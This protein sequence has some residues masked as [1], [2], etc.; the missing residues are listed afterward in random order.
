MVVQSTC[1]NNSIL[2]SSPYAV[3]MY[4]VLDNLYREAYGMYA[5]NGILF[6]SQ[7]IP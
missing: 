2:S 4:A 6:Q 1:R 3:A 7:R 5:C